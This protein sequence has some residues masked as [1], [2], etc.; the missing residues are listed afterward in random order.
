ML[1]PQVL[2]LTLALAPSFA[3]AAIFPPDSLVKMIDAKGFRK[4]MRENQTSIVAFVAPWC[5]HCQRMAPE[6]S[7][8]ALGLYPLVPAYAVDCDQDSNK[9]LCA[10]QGVK[11]FPT[12]KLFPRGK[13][14]APIEYNSGERTASALFY[15]ATRRIPHNNKKLYHVEDIPEWVAQNTDKPRVLLLTKEKKVPLLWQVLGN[16]YKDQLLLA[17]HRDRKGKSSVKLGYEAGEKKQAK[18]LLYPVGSTTPVRYEGLNKLDSLSKFFDSVLD[19]TADIKFLNEAARAEE[20]VP[21]EKELEIEQKQE[22]QRIALAHGGFTNLIDFEAAVKSGKAA[23]WHDVN[24]YPG[25]MGGAPP[26]K[27]A[28]E[29]RADDGE[30]EKAPAAA[31]TPSEESPKAKKEDPIHKMLK[32]AKEKAKTEAEAVAQ[33]K[34]P[35]ARDAASQTS[36]TPAV[37]TEAA[38]SAPSEPKATPAEPQTPEEPEPAK[39]EHIPDEL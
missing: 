2:A 5:G 32:A 37:E 30:A 14:M 39:N 29:K 10:E 15:F 24:G 21:D 9:R 33:P 13:T 12:V 11:G 18:V 28:D 27:K 6:Y 19:G 22:A 20:F 26:P 17:S 4:A 35:D 8:A 34:T 1:L 16:K 36:E 3:S 7:R 38:S 31:E 25:M 23:D